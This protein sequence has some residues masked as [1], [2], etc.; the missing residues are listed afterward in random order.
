[1]RI[2]GIKNI[3][4]HEAILSL[5]KFKKGKP[6]GRTLSKKIMYRSD[7]LP[8][9]AMPLDRI[10]NRKEL[11]FISRLTGWRWIKDAIYFKEVDHAEPYEHQEMPDL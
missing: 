2:V 1:M 9:K 5:I 3:D 6:F 11:R 10:L 8:L 7:I 4:S